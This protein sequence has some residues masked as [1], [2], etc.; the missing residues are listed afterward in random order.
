MGRAAYDNCV[1][2]IDDRLGR[3]IDELSSRGVLDQ[4][5]VIVTADHG[6]EFGENGFFEHGFDLYH[7]QVHVPLVVILPK[8]SRTT[9]VVGD[10]VS[11]RDL[12]ATIVDILGIASKSP[13]PG[14]SLARFW[15]GTT[16]RAAFDGSEDVLSEIHAPPG[17]N[18]ELGRLPGAPWPIVSLAAGDFLYIRNEGNHREELYDLHQDPQERRNLVDV[19]NKRDVLGRLRDRLLS[20]V[21]DLSRLKTPP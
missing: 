4:S 7:P 8:R 2:Y 1:A 3:L 5:L 14:R 13:F 17:E 10:V 19:D 16:G 21:G 6:E 11:L 18:A 20:S 15:N 12:P 9:G